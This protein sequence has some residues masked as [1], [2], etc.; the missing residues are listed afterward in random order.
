MDA[1]Q[2]RLEL[3][4]GLVLT[5]RSGVG[6]QLERDLGPDGQQF[7]NLVAALKLC[8]LSAPTPADLNIVEEDVFRVVGGTDDESLMPWPLGRS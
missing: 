7:K 6:V 3:K 1:L 2:E 8:R 5:D 4:V